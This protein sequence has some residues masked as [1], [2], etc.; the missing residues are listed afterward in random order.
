MLRK[1]ESLKVS[2]RLSS[3]E[4]S[5]DDCDLRATSKLETYTIS[6]MERE[7][8]NLTPWTELNRSAQILPTDRKMTQTLPTHGVLLDKSAEAVG[9]DTEDQETYCEVKYDHSGA[10]FEQSAYTRVMK[11]LSLMVNYK[12]MIQWF[13]VDSPEGTE[14]IK[15]TAHSQNVKMIVDS[16]YLKD[17]VSSSNY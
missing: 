10:E 14:V 6:Y 15:I 9:Y 3:F 7:V 2:A 13:A 17:K 12:N 11:I 16:T 1:R 8:L 4:E 5:E